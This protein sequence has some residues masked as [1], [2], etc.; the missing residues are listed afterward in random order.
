M[1]VGNA[2]LWQQSHRKR[3]GIDDANLFRF[4]IVEIIS[5]LIVVQAVV[6]EVEDG[7]DRTF[8]HTVD[9]PLQVFQLQVGDAD[10]FYNPFV[11]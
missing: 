2:P 11:P 1:P 10:M 4:E 8:G 3:G 5:Q 7:F 9:Y 6:A